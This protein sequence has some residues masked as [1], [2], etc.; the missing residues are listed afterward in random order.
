[1]Q[2]F[3]L[4]QFQLPLASMLIANALISITLFQPEVLSP[5]LGAIAKGWEIGQ[6]AKPLIAQKW[7]EAWEKPVAVWRLELNVQPIS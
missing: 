4:A 6:K 3:Y 5:L 2:A 1:L 7:E